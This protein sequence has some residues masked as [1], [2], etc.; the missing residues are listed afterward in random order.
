LETQDSAPSGPPEADASSSEYKRRLSLFDGTMV[1]VGG[2]VGSGIFA[3]PSE[4]AQ[5]VDTPALILVAWVL[6]GALALVGAL[7]FAELG[8]RRPEAGGGYVYLRETFGPL[9]GFLYGWKLLL[10]S[11]TGAIAALAIIFARYFVDLVGMGEPWISPIAVGALLF[12]SGINYLGVR[13]GSITQNIFTVLKMAALALL[14]VVGL[15]WGASEMVDPEATSEVAGSGF[16]GI[17]AA[18][19]VALIPVLFSHG[20]W[21]HVN[22]IAGEIKKPGRN[23]PL[24]LLIGVGL[25]VGTYLLANTAYLYALGVEGLAASTAPASDA[26]KNLWG[27]TGGTIMSAGIVASVFGILNLYIMAAPR[28]YQAMARDDLFFERFADLHPRYETPHRAILL[29]GGWAIILALSGTFGQLLQYVVFGDWIF[30]ALVVATLFVYRRWDR[31]GR[32]KPGAETSFRMFGYP[33]LPVLFILASGFV[34]VNSVYNEPL[35]A[36][37]GTVLIG[38]GVPAFLYWRSQNR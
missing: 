11:A 28:V 16:T 37:I 27:A 19:G 7:C 15:G 33:A 36:L 26:V 30:F 21:Q 22:H 35:N 14:I 20:G 2:I 34:V 23:L 4:V 32:S 1:V 9:W 29:Q 13:F 5:I 12:L 6:G 18:L 10:V 38:A 24:S 25:V 31:A 17:M 3:T 8:A